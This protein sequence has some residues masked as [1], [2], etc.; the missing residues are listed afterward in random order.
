M[1]NACYILLITIRSF[2]VSRPVPAFGEQGAIDI[3]Y[4]P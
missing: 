2:I 4:I 3:Y 1:F